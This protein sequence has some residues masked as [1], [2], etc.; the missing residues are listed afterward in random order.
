[1]VGSSLRARR[2]VVALSAGVLL[3]GISQVRDMPVDV[4]PEFTPPT[5]EVQ[6]EALGLSA[7][8][9]EQFITVPLEQDLLNGVA[10]LDE[11][12][13]ASVPGL[14]SIQM[15]FEP[16]TDLLDA[17]QV[18][19]ERISQAQVALPGVQSRPPQ[20]LQPLSSTSRVMMIG[21]SSDE[22]STIDMSLL[23]RWTIGPR[24][25]GVPGVANVAVWGF[26]DRQLQVLVDPERLRDHGV[27]LQQI[28]ETA[29]NAQLVCPLTFVECSTPG[30]GGLIE[31]PNQRI[32]V[33]HKAVLGTPEALAQVPIEDV[34]GKSLRLGDVTQIVE[35]H[36][37]L[38]GDA[39][40]TDLLLVVEK[41]PAAN[42]L[43]V[44]QGVEDA[45][46]ALRPGLS[47]VQIDSSLYRPATY[48]ETSRSNIAA[49]LLIAALLAVL[50][51][52][53]F[54]FEWRTTL[55]ATV[56]IMLSLTAAGIA[57]SLT[58]ASLNAMVVA[59]LV[60]ALVVVVDEAIIDVEN[61]AG[62]YHAYRSHEGERPPVM[63]VLREAALEM[64]S[65]SAYAGLII[66]VSVI[67]VSFTEGPFGAFF[68]SIGFSYAVTVLASMLVAVA[69]TP[70][71]GLLL[72]PKAPIARRESLVVRWLR[73]RYTGVLSRFLGS[74]RPAYV[75]AGVL[76]LAGLLAAP[77]LTRTTVPS[78]ND[79]NLLVHLNG[80][81]ST[82]LPEMRRV[83]ARVEQE[84]RSIPGVSDV[85]A[86]VGRA[87]L[88]D[89]VVG[90]NAGQ[91]WV[92]VDPE[93]DYSATV[94]AIEEVV[95]GYPGLESDVTTYPEQRIEEVLSG[96][97]APV[98]VRIYGQ[99]L[100]VLR[101]KGEEV[102]QIL[103]GIEGVVDPHVE[104]PA[105]EPTLEI[106]TDLALAE[107]HRIKPGDV[108]RAAATMLSGITVGSLFEEQ[109]VFEVVV[110]GTPETRSNLSSIN[111]LLIDTPG[112]GRVRLGDVAD[113]RIASSP[114]ALRHEAVSRYVD[115]VA[116]VSGRDSGSVLANL[117]DRLQQVDFQLEYHAEV[118][119]EFAER[120]AA[121]R[122]ALGFAV[123]TAIVIFL[124]LQAGL[125]SWRLAALAFVMLPLALVGGA[126]A[127]FIDGRTVS[128]G[129]IAG[130]YAVLGI[131]ARQVIVLLSHY[132]RLERDGEEPFGPELVLRGARERLTPI[133]TSG[134]TTALA[135]VP[136]VIAGGIAGLEIVHPMAIVVVG[137]LVTSTLLVLFVVPGL[138]L[139]FG[140]IPEAGTREVSVERLIDLTK[141]E[142][143]ELV[144]G[145]S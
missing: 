80:E 5:V 136:L 26:R 129:S 140:L 59:G 21:L 20:M 53:V 75:T 62:R 44:T 68:P 124:L 60:L 50:A 116:D 101:S 111:E 103:S 102:R 133:L 47:G 123:A 135:F 138:Y 109:K 108:R 65:A 128:V 54:L 126:I 100:E 57:L 93:A 31:T 130:F 132:R 113:V 7:A 63:G 39:V 8:E 30:T 85:G 61:L 40:G 104:L 38:I 14:S 118:L 42:T 131:A 96:P 145:G 64:R 25:L 17:R 81:T 106:Q 37:L 16:G 36:Q 143:R 77:F 11:I 70:A 46:D 72:L 91:L 98:V 114:T 107:R 94:A 32:T 51:L 142:E 1:M 97:E 105:Q 28:V 2:L 35:D 69:V 66:G 112:G 82:S 4:L 56:A 19:Q 58:Q 87:V 144:G 83:V 9:V 24:L 67:P 48:I 134:F 76:L 18:V 6:T 33:Q 73:P 115:V 139:R 41:F 10:F 78:F 88:S 125:G 45:L 137:G 121:G 49:A 22:L 89:Q 120:Q 13:S 23:S 84:L 12:R 99:D 86:H 52:G 110:W 55:I 71:L 74:A 119:G 29:A 90:A 92:T 3:L 127:A 141:Q 27:S 117:D 15:I 43:D 34:E 122:R 95:G 79:T